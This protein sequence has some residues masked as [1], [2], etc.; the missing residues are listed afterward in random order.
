MNWTGRTVVRLFLL[1]GGSAFL[2][3]GVLGGDALELL[4]GALGVALG[5]AGLAAEIR[6]DD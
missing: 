3:M 4:I 5:A 6:A 2:V 1:V